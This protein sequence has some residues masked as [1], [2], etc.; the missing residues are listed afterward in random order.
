M[1]QENHS[2]VL[3]IGGTG[4]SGST[5]LDI[6]LGQIDGFCS[7]GELRF[8]WD[9]GF[10]Q[11][12]LCGCGKPFM[13]CEFW[14]AVIQEAFA[15]FQNVDYEKMTELRRSAERRIINWLSF[16]TSSAVLA[17]Y[18]EYLDAYRRL[19]C[20]IRKVSGCEVIVDSS[21][22]VA[23]GYIMSTIPEVDLYTV[24]LTR[25]S[26]A[27][28]YSWQRRKIRP[29]IHWEQHYMSQ[30]GILKSAGRWNRFNVLAH[31]LVTTSKKYAFLRYED[32]AIDPQKGLTRLLADLQMGEFSLEFLD[33][34][35]ASLK[36]CH[37]V[38]G[39]PM[40]FERKE[41]KI[42]PDKQWQN[43]M[44]RPEKWLVTLLT[45]P[46]LLKYGYLNRGK[47]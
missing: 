40:R 24:H 18:Q 15:G 9:R 41:I 3:F 25:D 19:Y 38:S 2:K 16:N 4:R 13:E 5:L 14:T 42:Q 26:R 11:N 33:G 32:L 47:A 29:E 27:V 45:W 35:R 22:Y 21:K 43:G 30:R 7:T 46:L 31:K 20:A 8:I 34:F 10:G 36:T 17:P 44:A 28:A 1:V 23:H 37:T 12:Q 39:N 6:L